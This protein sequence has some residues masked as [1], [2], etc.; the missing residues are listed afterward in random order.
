M[1][2]MQESDL[3]RPRGHDVDQEAYPDALEPGGVRLPLR[4]RHEPG[5]DLD[6]VS[7]EVPLAGLNLLDLDK[8]EWLVPGM[9]A[10]KI[11]VLLRALPK[12]IRTRFSPMKETAEG[13]VEALTFGEGDLYVALAAHLARVGG[14]EVHPEDFD[15]VRVGGHLSMRV[16][17][18]D[19][20]GAEVASS[21]EVAGLVGELREQ[22]R[23]AFR[24][25]VRE[26]AG[27]I[28]STGLSVIE[29][30]EIPRTYELPG[31][32]GEL[33]AWPALVDEGTTIGVRL[34]DSSSE[35]ER[36]HR[37]GLRRA[38]GLM[39]QDALVGLV[40]WLLEGRQLELAFA[41][42]G[43]KT[44]MRA[45]LELVVLDATFLADVDSV[46]GI[47][48]QAALAGVYEAGFPE[49]VESSRTRR[50][51]LGAGAATTE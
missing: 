16:I 30:E 50:G 21:R 29:A 4:Y 38:L 2:Q 13:A 19:E 33:T 23:A 39:A 27:T 44:L 8:L 41:P 11:E 24:E 31:A 48:T 1:L 49:L 25:R 17:V 15:R 43:E 14:V 26:C 20:S 47:R 34:F 18:L 3:L 45:Q 28:E 12:R 51:D 36:H 22:A 32:G 35:A 46:G 5:A 7:L 9:L 40:D 6:G 42:L 37:E 10:E